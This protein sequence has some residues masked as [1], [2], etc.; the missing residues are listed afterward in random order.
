MLQFQTK[1][2][3]LK[4]G[5]FYHKTVW[6]FENFTNSNASSLRNDANKSCRQTLVVFCLFESY[7]MFHVSFLVSIR[8]YDFFYGSFLCAL[9]SRNSMFCCTNKHADTL[10]PRIYGVL[11]AYSQFE[12][13]VCC[14]EFSVCCTNK[15]TCGSRVVLDSA[16]SSAAADLVEHETSGESH[17]LLVQHCVQCV[18][19]KL[20]RSLHQFSASST[21]IITLAK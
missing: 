12:N 11:I 16:Q 15:S 14:F 18:D 4:F 3:R 17:A 10:T 1:T 7:E 21:M 2:C 8:R 6:V 20:I 5:H 13:F 19:E 9:Q